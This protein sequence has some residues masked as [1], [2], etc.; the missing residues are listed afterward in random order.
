MAVTSLLCY[1]SDTAV[2][3]HLQIY[4][5]AI[6]KVCSSEG[7]VMGLSYQVEVFFKT[8]KFYNELYLTILLQGEFH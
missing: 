2:L 6:Q 7:F 5:T 3:K 4:G 1:S 8:D